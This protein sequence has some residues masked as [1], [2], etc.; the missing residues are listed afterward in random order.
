LA[1]PFEVEGASIN[2]LR[3]LIAITLLAIF[4]LPFGASL[5]AL[6]PKSETNLPACCRRSGGHH[7]NLGVAER[8]GVSG[9]H[10]VVVS[11]EK[12]PFCPGAL[13]VTT[14]PTK[15]R[16]SHSRIIHAHLISY[17]TVTA[18]IGLRHRVLRNR[19]HSERGPPTQIPL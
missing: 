8:G 13:N 14:H 1:L 12:C 3:K 9:R 17:S 19:S 16:P 4:G 18:Q 2:V 5:F 7:C 6:T 11:Q 10:E 15:F